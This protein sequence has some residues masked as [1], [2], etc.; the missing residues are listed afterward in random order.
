MRVVAI[1][2]AMLAVS[3]VVSSA[4]CVVR[5]AEP[6]HRP[7]CHR[8]IPAKESPAPQPPCDSLMV[9]GEAPYSR[10]AVAPLTFGL[11]VWAEV[12]ALPALAPVPSRIAVEP[13]ERPP[14]SPLA[15]NLVVLRI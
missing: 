9:A 5:C 1:F 13:W 15:A 2:L 3:T 4:Q 11:M 8:Q 14:D 6:P 12:P 7:P 10:L